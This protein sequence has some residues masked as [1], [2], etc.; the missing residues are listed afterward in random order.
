MCIY[1]YTVITDE[2]GNGRS[3]APVFIFVCNKGL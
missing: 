1:I 3:L 2:M